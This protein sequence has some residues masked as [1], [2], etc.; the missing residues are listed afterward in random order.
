MFTINENANLVQLTDEMQA[1]AAEEGDAVHIMTAKAS[2]VA[3]LG[4]GRPLGATFTPDG[5]T[6]YICDSS[7]GLTRLANPFN[8]KSKVELIAS[9]VLDNGE[10]TPIRLADDVVVG[11][12]TGKVYFTDATMVAPEK[13]RSFIYDVMYASKVELLTA[14]PSG[15]LLQYDPNTDEV[16]VLTRGLWFGNGVSIDPEE[17]Y[18][19]YT[20][21]FSLRIAKYYLE[22]EKKGAI[23]YL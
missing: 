22:G 5:S 4:P 23:E 17:S 8:P 16:T 15:R 14:N 6:L 12:K 3:D 2:I 10:S 11:P 7:L 20:E 18:L 13:D 19:V 21:T 9:S 1:V